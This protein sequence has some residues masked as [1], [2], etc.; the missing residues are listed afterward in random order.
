MRQEYDHEGWEGKDVEGDSRGIFEGGLLSHIFLYS[1]EN[2]RKLQSGWPVFWPRFEPD[3]S[4]VQLPSVTS[5]VSVRLC[6]SIRT[7]VCLCWLLVVP[8]KRN[9]LKQVARFIRNCPRGHWMALHMIWLW[10]SRNAFIARLK[11]SHATDMFMH[12]SP[13]TS[14]DFRTL[15]PVVWKL[16]RWW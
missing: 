16:W 3:T 11:G 14:Y 10:S 1:E 4:R 7:E 13:C 9:W 6:N 2:L 15:T 12:V 8:L 5:S